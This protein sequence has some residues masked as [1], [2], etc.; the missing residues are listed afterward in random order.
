[1]GDHH[2][3]AA[4][5]LDRVAQRVDGL[6]VEVV[7]G[8]VKQQDVRLGQGDARKHDARLLAACGGGSVRGAGGGG[9]G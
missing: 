8:L 1:V 4:E 9:W 2:H 3:A 7:G 5:L 6:H